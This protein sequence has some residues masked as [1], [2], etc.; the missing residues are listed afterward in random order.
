MFK[1]KAH[2]KEYLDRNF[3]DFKFNFGETSYEIF[4]NYYDDVPNLELRKIFAISHENLNALFSFMNDKARTNNHFNADPSRDLLFIINR[5]KKL[6]VNLKETE[7]AFTLDGYYEKI[8]SYCESFLSPSH[9]S[10]IPEDFTDITLIEIKPIFFLGQAVTT[11]ISQL[12]VSSPMEE[13]GEGS[14]A[15]VYK[16]KDEHYNKFFAI[17]KAKTNLNEQ[18]LKRFQREYNELQKLNS[19]YIVEVYNYDEE[20]NQYTMEYVDKTLEEYINAKSGKLSAGEKKSLIFQTLRAFQYIH[21]KE[22][23]HRDISCTN[24]LIKEYDDKVVNIKISDF[25]LVKIRTSNLTRLGTEFKGSLNDPRLHEIGFSQYEKEHEIYALTRLISF[26][27]SGRTTIP[28]YENE[29]IMS[30]ITK[31]THHDLNQRYSNIEE[32]ISA[33]RQIQFEIS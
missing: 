11:S 13:I 20:N 23:L 10:S 27:L 7:Y 26:I 16:Y 22:L 31:G 17:K 12:P 19:P 6:Q 32:M 4:L 21:S 14:Y 9:G 25:G 3:I 24:V 8:L 1:I 2:I 33:F 5:L 18:E 30:F 15:V 29:K 28:S